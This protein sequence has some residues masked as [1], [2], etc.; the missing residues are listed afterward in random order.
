MT[1][2]QQ[3]TTLRD[4]ARDQQSYGTPGSIDGHDERVP[5]QQIRVGEGSSI[6]LRSLYRRDLDRW[7]EIEERVTL[8]R[9]PEK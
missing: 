4:L 5:D 9:D 8:R 6:G 7:L 1:E 3:T 2:V